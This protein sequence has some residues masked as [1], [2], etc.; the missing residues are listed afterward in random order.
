MCIGSPSHTRLSEQNRRERYGAEFMQYNI[1]TVIPDYTPSLSVSAAAYGFKRKGGMLNRRIRQL[2]GIQRTA[3]WADEVNR[4]A[5]AIPLL[6]ESVSRHFTETALLE[7]LLADAEEIRNTQDES[8]NE[9]AKEISRLVS[10]NA[11]PELELPKSEEMRFSVEFCTEGEAFC[12][13]RI[14]WC[15]KVI[16]YEQEYFRLSENLRRRVTDIDGFAIA[17]NTL[18]AA[19]VDKEIFG[20][21][22]TALTAPDYNWISQIALAET[23]FCLLTPE[24]RENTISAPYLTKLIGMFKTYISIEEKIDKDPAYGKHVHKE[25][26][27]CRKNATPFIRSSVFRQCKTPPVE[28]VFNTTDRRQCTF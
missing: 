6:P 12:E 25:I 23:K 4:A 20:V 24:E 13:K 27:R 10:A 16:G 19:M 8:L 17:P 26:R 9:R 18:R 3:Q 15:T 21:M 1:E 11:A 5:A 2:D 7:Q 14:S 28:N 22:K